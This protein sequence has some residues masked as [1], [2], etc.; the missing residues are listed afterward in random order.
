MNILGI[1]AAASPAS[2]C[3]YLD[4]TVDQRLCDDPR[5]QA[6]QLLELIEQVMN[7]HKVTLQS[8]DGLAVGRGPG[9]FTGLRVA[10]SLAQGLAYSAG[11]PVANVSSLAAVAHLAFIEQ[12]GADVVSGESQSQVTPDATGVT[13]NDALLVCMDARKSQVY[14]AL[15]EADELARPRL[16]SPEVVLDPAEVV[17]Q[18]KGKAQWGAGNGFEQYPELAALDLRAIKNSNPCARAVALRAASGAVSFEEAY[19]AIPEYVRNNVTH[20]S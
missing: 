4:G 7:D 18:F 9:S 16:V 5:A 17:A 8:L 15:Y 2:V 11:K 20:G 12:L 13:L 1:E 3:L 10:A 14:C 6:E 19:L